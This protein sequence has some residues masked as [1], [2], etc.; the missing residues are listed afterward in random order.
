A[1]RVEQDFVALCIGESRTIASAE[2][3]GRTETLKSND[4]LLAFESDDDRFQ[5]LQM[6]RIEREFSRLAVRHCLDVVRDKIVVA[7]RPTTA[8][9]VGPRFKVT[10]SQRNASASPDRG[11]SAESSFAIHLR[12]WMRALRRDLRIIQGLDQTVRSPCPRFNHNGRDG[13]SEK[14]PCDRDSSRTSADYAYGRVE[15]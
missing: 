11:R 14:L 8:S 9:H 5:C 15:N 1:R 10:W 3:G 6:L 12:W 13:R 7:N 2:I 4:D